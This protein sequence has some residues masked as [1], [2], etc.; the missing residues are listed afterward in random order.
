MGDLLAIQM[1]DVEGAVTIHC[2]FHSN[3]WE[4]VIFPDLPPLHLFTTTSWSWNE[5]LRYAE[6]RKWFKEIVDTSEKSTEKL[7]CCSSVNGQMQFSSRCS[8]L[9]F[10][11]PRRSFTVYWEIHLISYSWPPWYLHW[12]PSKIYQPALGCIYITL[13]LREASSDANKCLRWQRYRKQ[14]ISC[15]FL[16]AKIHWKSWIFHRE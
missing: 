11:M 12:P 6:Q 9:A 15:V 16:I 3:C 10:Q 5:S 4:I 8:L 7:A 14:W 13:D 1:E 2:I